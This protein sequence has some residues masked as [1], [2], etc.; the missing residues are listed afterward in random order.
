MSSALALGYHDNLGS[1]DNTANF[2]LVLRRMALARMYSAEI[3]V[4]MFLGRPPR[5]RRQ[6]I[7]TLLLQDCAGLS[8]PVNGAD[9][10]GG[11]PAPQHQ[12][13]FG[14]DTRWSA[15]YATIKEDIL[16]MYRH[17]HVQDRTAIAR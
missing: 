12:L 2:I 17:G 4:S 5:L 11:A 9:R 6:D 13:Q 10:D 16:A 3:N 8:E 1:S 15:K 7:R 14:A